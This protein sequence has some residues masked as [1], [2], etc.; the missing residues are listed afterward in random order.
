MHKMQQTTERWR[1]STSSKHKNKRVTSLQKIWIDRLFDK[2]IKYKILIFA[3]FIS[4]F[5]YCNVCNKTGLYIKFLS[6]EKQ[7]KWGF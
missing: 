6:V 7:T 3:G 5:F 4:V 1:L 2:M